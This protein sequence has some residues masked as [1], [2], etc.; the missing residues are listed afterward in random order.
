MSRAM[1]VFDNLTALEE[2]IKQFPNRAEGAINKVLHNDG[3]KIV[4]QEMTNLIPV[5]RENKKHAK[6]S[7]WYTHETGN[8][9]FVVKTKGRAANK[10]GSYGYLVF[11]DEGRGPSNPWEQNFSGRSLQ[12]STPKVLQKIHGAL[13]KL[14]EEGL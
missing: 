2:R 10:P 14:L 12:K 13:D 7:K 11:P 4:T 3:V 8:L 9:E 1:I 6:Q 5:S